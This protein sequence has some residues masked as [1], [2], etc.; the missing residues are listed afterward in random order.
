M[1]Y[2]IIKEALFTS[3]VE[4][5]LDKIIH[6]FE[7]SSD[8][9]TVAI[10]DFSER[11]LILSLEEKD[12]A[13]EKISILADI[14]GEENTTIA[15]VQFPVKNKDSVYTDYKSPLYGCFIPNGKR[16]KEF[17][18][19]EF[20]M[21]SGK[22]SPKLISISDTDC[23]FPKI[24]DPILKMLEMSKDN[25][26]LTLGEVSYKSKIREEIFDEAINLLK[27]EKESNVFII[28]L[29]SSFGE[30]INYLSTEYSIQGV[31]FCKDRRLAIIGKEIRKC[32]S[33]NQTILHLNMIAI[34]A[35][36]IN[37]NNLLSNMPASIYIIV[38]AY[39]LSSQNLHTLVEV[40]QLC[41]FDIALVSGE[42]GKEADLSFNFDSRISIE[43]EKSFWRVKNG[44]RTSRGSNNNTDSSRKSDPVGAKSPNR[45]RR[46]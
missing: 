32:L 18:E 37:I 39:D 31:S 25:I 9:K 42:L 12:L 36:I 29:N 11:I 14:F 45:R 10:F 7:S 5:L 21:L 30:V 44:R 24:D 28:D 15:I 26:S 46:K 17:K 38:L 16:Q 27:A 13:T 4:V 6:K 8:G 43:K 2:E 1:K 20:D 35:M 19:F 40:L 34:E 3:E 22:A 33:L 23:K 41:E